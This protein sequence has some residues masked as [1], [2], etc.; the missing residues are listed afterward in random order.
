MLDSHDLACGAL[1][2]L[3]YHPKATTY[4][5]YGQID[6]AHVFDHQTMR[7][8]PSSSSIWYWLAMVDSFVIVASVRNDDLFNA[9]VL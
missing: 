4:E 6:E 8:L 5:E 9:M 3:V 2:G 7:L 1:N